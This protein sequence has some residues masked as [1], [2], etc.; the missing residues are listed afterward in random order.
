MDHEGGEREL[1]AAQLVGDLVSFGVLDVPA[2]EDD[3]IFVVTDKV[4]ELG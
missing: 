4:C 3:F 1:G 2:P